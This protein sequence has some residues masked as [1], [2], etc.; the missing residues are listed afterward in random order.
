MLYCKNLK[1]TVLGM[2]GNLISSNN[3]II[4]S[5]YVG[6]YL[7]KRLGVSLEHTI[8]KSDLKRYGRTNIDVTLIGEGIYY[9]DFSVKK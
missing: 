2:Q 9:L 1:E 6:K 7:R 8:T 3:I 5:G 4:V